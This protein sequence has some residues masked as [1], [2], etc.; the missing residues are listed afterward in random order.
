MKTD[1]ILSNPADKVD[2]PKIEEYCPK[3]LELKE[4]QDKRAKISGHKMKIW[5]FC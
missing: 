4:I 1:I 5:T 2:L 3:L